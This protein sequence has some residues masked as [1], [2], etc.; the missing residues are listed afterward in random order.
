MKTKLVAGFI[1]L[2]MLSS[3]LQES[4][5]AQV[6][7]ISDSI[8]TSDFSGANS[9]AN[10]GGPIKV[11]WSASASAA[12]S[13]YRIYRIINGKLVQQA[14]VS[15]TVF[16][17]VDS[18]VLP[19]QF[20]EYVVRATDPLGREDANLKKVTA[21]SYAGII[22]ATADLDNR[23]SVSV[24]LNTA[25]GAT[26]LR[27]YARRINDSSSF[28][29]VATVSPSLSS[30]SVPALSPTEPSGLR[31]G[32]SY[33]FYVRAYFSSSN[34]EDEN[35]SI[36]T[37]QTSSDSYSDDALGLGYLF[38][39]FSSV[40][41]FGDSPNAPVP[42][43]LAL[44]NSK[45]V[46]IRW[47]AFD[48]DPATKYRVVRVGTGNSI[49]INTSIP[50]TA[51]ENGSCVACDDITNLD[52]D[53]NSRMCK[54]INVGA[55]PAVY[56]YVVGYYKT[57]VS[58][59][60]LEEIPAQNA[61]IR[62]KVQIPPNNMNLV[63]RS[64]VNYEMCKMMSRAS[65]PKKN[66]RCAFSGPGD[67]PRNSG[68]GKPNLNLDDGFYDF[69]FNLFVDRYE[70]GCKWTRAVDKGGTAC[71]NSIGCM[72]TSFPS[73][74]VGVDGDVFYTFAPSRYL[75]TS[76]PTNGGV[77]NPAA[78]DFAGIQG[79]E[80]NAC[81]IKIQGQWRTATRRMSADNTF[82]S[83]L[84]D[85]SLAVQM[86][87]TDPGRQGIPLT[88][89][90]TPVSRPQFSF[91]SGQVDPHYGKKR[92]PRM[93]EFRA[94]AGVPIDAEDATSFEM[95]T[96]LMANLMSGSSHS[97]IVTMGYGCNTRVLNTQNVLLFPGGTGQSRPNT[98]SDMIAPQQS[99]AWNQELETLLAG[100]S[101]YT[102]F[103][104]LVGPKYVAFIGSK[105]T[106]HCISRFGL[107]D[108]IGNA[109][110]Y[111]SETMGSCRGNSAPI[112]QCL[113]VSSAYDPDKNDFSNV[114]WDG[115]TF[116]RPT[117]PGGYEGLALSLSA[118]GNYFNIP[119]GLPVISNTGAWS[120]S[121]LK[122]SASS[123]FTTASLT[124]EYSSY[125]STNSKYFSLGGSS[126]YQIHGRF[127]THAGDNGH[128]RPESFRC[129]L[130]AE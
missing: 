97:S 26:S 124:N 54:D 90:M 123:F 51:T 14:V 50:C 56:D 108:T 96:S 30:Y 19:G 43:T 35:T 78:A 16:Q 130:P 75:T 122:S 34:Y 15:S 53:V 60:F 7:Q 116:Y 23:G 22:S 8:S 88:S 105:A 47:L 67:Y 107:Q 55:P 115:T 27:I 44:P 98:F 99:L 4:G 101:A 94:Y 61:N 125:L 120:Q 82:V 85:P 48:S 109:S 2:S 95:S 21:Y 18:T 5:P 68:P 20:Y 126:R 121:I 36:Q 3:C 127:S 111:V 66:M 92:L 24:A 112:G 72:G 1:A 65:D 129:V 63:H 118:V 40:Q 77:H 10:T 119:L 49:N 13:G 37:V 71:G 81:S 59:T 87:T 106:S 52:A 69:G 100:D 17:F 128:V 9:A 79:R 104:W 114:I 12:T 46:W 91:C 29:V 32:T 84:L 25:P 102:G 11:S 70:V 113:G 86:I 41:A 39:G 73:N 74:S 6:S 64:A 62:L 45:Q 28:S 103:T 93:R 117:N 31:S 38:R 58:E 80:S 89:E 76:P 57:Q 42:E 110:E 33:E 83:E